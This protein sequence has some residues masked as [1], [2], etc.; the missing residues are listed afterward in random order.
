[1]CR[2]AIFYFYFVVLE[3]QPRGP[4]NLRN[5]KAKNCI[6]KLIKVYLEINIK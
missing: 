6:N 5:F 4:Y 1:M 3:I 2:N